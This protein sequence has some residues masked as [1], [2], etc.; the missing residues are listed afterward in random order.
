MSYQYI[1]KYNAKSYTKGREGHKIK[2]I[3]IHH[4]GADG[5][6]FEG[7]VNWFANNAPTSAH[8]VVEGGR[9]ACLVD[10]SD[11]AYHAGNW[12]HNL[13]SIGIECR[14]EMSAEDF[15]TLVELVRYLFS[16]VGKVKIVGHQD[17]VPTSC[18]GRY[19]AR[20]PELRRLAEGG[21][22][23]WKQNNKG[24]WYQ[25]SDG[26]YPTSKWEK[27]NGNWFYFDG[28][29][30]MLE[31]QWLYYNKKWYYLKSGGYM[32]TGWQK[33]GKEWYYLNEDGSMAI[34]WKK[35]HDKWYYMTANRGNM[36]SNEFKEVG[37][38]LYKFNSDG[39]MATEGTY[40]VQANGKVV[41]I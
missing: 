22:S 40:K 8:Y 20:L 21:G 29:G 28:R 27:I 25:K 24:W 2:E 6:T 11:T 32:A 17:I 19:Y 14:P 38:V 15:A 34:G 37:G 39:S 13:E 31:N 9:V 4:W 36:L 33:V 7:V 16:E 41:K 18:P 12:L 3:V 5:Q 30:Y 1:T 23:G 35:Y 10:L 26:S